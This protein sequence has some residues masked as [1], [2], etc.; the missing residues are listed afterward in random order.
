MCT[1]S[2]KR[3]N[4]KPFTIHHPSRKCANILCTNASFAQYCYH[5]CCFTFS[6]HFWISRMKTWH[7]LY[8]GFHLLA[9]LP[10]FHLRAHIISKMVS[11]H[12]CVFS[13]ISLLVF[14]IFCWEH[15]QINQ[16]I[17][18][19]ARPAKKAAFETCV[20]TVSGSSLRPS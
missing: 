12:V 6:T 4:L 7:S 13:F 3:S 2:G 15:H 5:S 10:S 18:I 11:C 16:T 17:V 8:K 19:I 1:L 20:S 9:N 14:G